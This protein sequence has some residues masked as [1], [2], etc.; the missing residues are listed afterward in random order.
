MT[1]P[2]FLKSHRMKLVP[3]IVF[4]ALC[5]LLYGMGLILP[6]SRPPFMAA[7]VAAFGVGSAA[8]IMTRAQIQFQHAGAQINTF[9]EPRAFQADGI[10]ARS[11]NPMYLAFMLAL[12]AV[13]MLVWH[14]LAIIGPLAFFAIANWWYIPIEEDNMAATFGEDYLSYKTRVRRWI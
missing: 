1:D 11:R 8:H 9:L 4:G 3:P 6:P 5:L 13:A 12:I 14:P 7:L 10:Y 2:D